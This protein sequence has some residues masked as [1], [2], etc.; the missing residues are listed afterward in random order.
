[1]W[2]L[3]RSDDYKYLLIGEPCREHAYLYVKED[4]GVEVEAYD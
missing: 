2:I 3:E 1:M 4:E